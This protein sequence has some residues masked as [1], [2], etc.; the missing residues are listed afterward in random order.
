MLCVKSEKVASVR[1]DRVLCVW[2][3]R[4]HYC[5]GAKTTLINTAEESSIYSTSFKKC[6]NRN[7]YIVHECVKLG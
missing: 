2:S 7:Q 6:F 4:C 3:E 1:T 5:G